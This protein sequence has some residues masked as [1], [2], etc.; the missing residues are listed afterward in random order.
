ML[1]AP[2]QEEIMNRL[3]SGGEKTR[4]RAPFRRPLETDG[5]EPLYTV[6]YSR[7]YDAL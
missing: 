2:L 1:A 3:L 6:M 7:L 4:D 5:G